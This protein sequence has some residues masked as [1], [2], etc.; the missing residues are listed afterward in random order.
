MYFCTHP[1]LLSQNI[2]KEVGRGGFAVV[3]EAVNVD[4]NEHHAMKRFLLDSI[5][6]ESLGQIEVDPESPLFRSHFLYLG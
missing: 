1:P 6:A 3:F 4:T 5:D 2:L